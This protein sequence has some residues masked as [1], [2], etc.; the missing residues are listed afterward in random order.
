MSDPIQTTW[1]P[2]DGG[3][4]A[5]MDLEGRPVVGAGVPEGGEALAYWVR[6][7]LQASLDGGPQLLVPS[8]AREFGE[9]L[10][11]L[12]DV[13]ERSFVVFDGEESS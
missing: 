11:R 5:R 12:A 10:I 8:K 6:L 4:W 13:A 7:H 1:E 9:A 2:S 3:S